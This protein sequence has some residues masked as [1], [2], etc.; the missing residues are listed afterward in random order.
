MVVASSKVP[1]SRIRAQKKPPEK[2]G[3][4]LTLKKDERIRART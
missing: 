2:G 4:K 1:G 3:L